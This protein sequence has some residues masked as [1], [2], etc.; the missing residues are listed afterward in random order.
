MYY[1]LWKAFVFQKHSIAQI[2]GFYLFDCNADI[3]KPTIYL[4]EALPEILR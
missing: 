3:P 4:L 2:H 1:C